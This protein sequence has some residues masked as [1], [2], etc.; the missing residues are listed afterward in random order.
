MYELYGLLYESVV[1]YYEAS[2]VVVVIYDVLLKL[3]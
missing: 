2:V 3:L 1:D